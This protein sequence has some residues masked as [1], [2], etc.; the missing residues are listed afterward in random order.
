MRNSTIYVAKTRKNDR[1][2]NKNKIKLCSDIINRDDIDKLRSWLLDMPQLTKGQETI[3]FEKA[4]ANFTQCEYAVFCNSGSSANLLIISALQQSGRLKNNK[5]VVPQISWSTTVFPIMQLGLTP[6]LCDCDMTNL[7]MS[8][9]DLENII[10]KED[11]A[12]IMLV[13]VLGLDSN[14]EQIINL[15]KDKNILVIEDTCESL[16]SEVLN[17]KLGSFGIASS[18][19]FYFGHHISTIEGGMVCTNDK[20]LG[21]IIKMIRSHGWDRDLDETAKY[22][23]RSENNIKDESIDAIYTFYHMG[24]NLRSTDL[25]AFIGIQQLDKIPHIVD[26]RQRNYYYYL[27]E[28]EPRFWKPEK[29]VNQNI[30]SSMGYP[31]MLKNKDIMYHIFKTNNIECRPLI[32]GSMGT[33]PAWKKYYKEFKSKN[34]D[35]VDNY[36]MYLPNHQDLKESD[37]NIIC[38]FINEYGHNV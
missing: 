12:A 19:S 33:Q 10:N 36:G 17:R 5:I 23:Y 2:M 26:K 14:I 1:I 16:G 24:F 22:K 9:Q 31:V 7:G 3:T 30:V 29:T 25:Q 32:S 34:S 38:N 6:I 4:F 35:L 28:I 15:C 27:N 37:I 21:D 11:P 8:I 20:E 18:F 13:H